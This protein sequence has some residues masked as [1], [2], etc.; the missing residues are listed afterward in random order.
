MKVQIPT[1]FPHKV[2]SL[3]GWRG[4][5]YK[6]KSKQQ[7]DGKDKTYEYFKLVYRVDGARKTKGFDS[8]EATMK[9]AA[10]L[11][12]ELTKA[13]AGSIVLSNGAGAIYQQAMEC[14]G[15]LGSDA[16]AINIVAADYVAARQ[17]FGNMENPPSMRELAEF[18]KQRRGLNLPARTVQQVVDEL[19]KHKETAQEKGDLSERHVKDLDNRLN[20]FAKDFAC[21]IADAD[22]PKVAA[23][24]RGLGLSARSQNNFRTA[25]QNLMTFAKSCGYLPRDWNELDTVP[26]A[27]Q[28]GGTVEIFT[29]DE[30]NK[31]LTQAKTARYAKLL[32]FVAIGGF[33]GLRSAELERLTWQKV[34]L[35][36]G[37][38]T[39][40]ATV[41]KTNSRRIVPIAANLRTWLAPITEKK[42]HVCVYQNVTN[43]LMKLAKAAGVKW[44][45]NALRHSYASYRLAI[46]QDPAKVAFE[47][48][49]SPKMIQQHYRELVRPE[50]GAAWFAVAPDLPAN[51]VD[52][53]TKDAISPKSNAVA[54][55]GP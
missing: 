47:M 24:L 18:F 49:N 13:N 14:L 29:P 36:R 34:D 12:K 52:L 5:I 43:E 10:D 15:E 27:K 20:R 23:W 28:K 48:G 26:T 9:G 35:K 25:I 53:P 30:I 17:S 51:V 7:V 41:A 22:G 2:E 11:L 38:I 3:V 44:K 40:D 55:A 4:V 46:V 39:I 33:A 1:E 42:G 21:Q 6:S 54:L 37:Y 19:V 8:I 32:A 50:D 45:Q 31:L 16:P